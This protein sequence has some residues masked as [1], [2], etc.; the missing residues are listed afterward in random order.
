MPVWWPSLIRTGVVIPAVR[1]RR[2]AD[3]VSASG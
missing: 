2:A 3:A 1:R